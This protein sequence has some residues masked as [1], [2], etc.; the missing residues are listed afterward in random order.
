VNYSGWQCPGEDLSRIV[1]ASERPLNNFFT[2]EACANRIIGYLGYANLKRKN[3]TLK[4]IC[5]NVIDMTFKTY[6]SNL[7][8]VRYFIKLKA[9]ERPSCGRMLLIVIQDCNE[10]VK[11]LE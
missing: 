11:F 3:I 5:T 7:G 6:A 1:S 4:V 8:Q 10:E 9:I 2:C